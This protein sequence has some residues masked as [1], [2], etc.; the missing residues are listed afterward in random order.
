MAHEICWD[1]EVGDLISFD[2]KKE[3]LSQPGYPHNA[4]ITIDKDNTLEVF[5][6]LDRRQQA[7]N[8]NQWELVR[9]ELFWLIAQ[10]VSLRE[11]R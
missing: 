8:P 3:T 9:E 7:K 11:S 1:G 5:Q 2:I 10:R 4:R 6:S